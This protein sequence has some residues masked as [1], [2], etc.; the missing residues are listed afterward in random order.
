MRQRLCAPGLACVPPRFLLSR[1][2]AP[3]AGWSP[4]TSL[5]ALALDARRSPGRVCR[6]ACVRGAEAPTRAALLALQFS[7][8]L[9]CALVIPG[10]LPP[11]FVTAVMS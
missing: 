11:S 8:W 6:G 2:P 7:G 10:P 1:D 9:T 3:L 4:Q 5:V